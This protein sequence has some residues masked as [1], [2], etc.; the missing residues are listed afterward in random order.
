MACVAFTIPLYSNLRQLHITFLYIFT[1]FFCSK[2]VRYTAIVRGRSQTSFV[3][4][5]VILRLLLKPRKGRDS[6][7]I[8]RASGSIPAEWLFF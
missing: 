4:L 8:A 7:A 2:S 1:H 3:S 5:N 6:A